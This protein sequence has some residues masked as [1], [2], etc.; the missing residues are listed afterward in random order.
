MYKSNP[1]S[2]ESV[3]VKLSVIRE[4]REEMGKIMAVGMDCITSRAADLPCFY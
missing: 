1:G 2:S 3:S 4:K